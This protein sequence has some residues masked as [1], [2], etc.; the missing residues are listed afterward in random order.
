M[1]AKG[2]KKK[3]PRKKTAK[4]KA[5]TAAAAPKKAA[6]KTKAPARKVVKKVTITKKRARKRAAT[7]TGANQRVHERHDLPDVPEIE[8]ELFG[9]QRDGREFGIG[10][11]DPGRKF[12]TLGV[13]TNLSV[14]GMLA[15]VAD[16]LTKGSHC[17]VRFINASAGVRPEHR[18]G[19]ILRSRQLESGECE[20]AVNFDNPL[21]MLDIDALIASQGQ[22]N[23]T[24]GS[25]SA[26]C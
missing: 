11:P 22:R 17:L 15:R 23:G 8:V 25:F 10:P 14:S 21:E 16:E 9:Y 7:G 4:K 26:P 18:W 1:T 24:P 2:A 20:V 3:S 6:A 5:T 13:T 19:L 12:R